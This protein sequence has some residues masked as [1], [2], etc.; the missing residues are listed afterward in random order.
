MTLGDNTDWPADEPKYLSSYDRPFVVV[1]E[2]LSSED[3]LAEST[4]TCVVGIVPPGTYQGDLVCT[5]VESRVALIFSQDRN[6]TTGYR[7][8]SRAHLDFEQL[9]KSI[10]IKSQLSSGKS[11][12]LTTSSTGEVHSFCWPAT[13]SIDMST[14]QDVTRGILSHRSYRQEGSRLELM[15]ASTGDA[16]LA[17]S[18]VR[19]VNGADMELRQAIST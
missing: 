15:P 18:N 6:S 8:K 3:L 10:P 12:E 17:P 16:Q 1:T 2:L 19:A 5:F 14:L 9:A 4:R 13:I 11:I 7:L